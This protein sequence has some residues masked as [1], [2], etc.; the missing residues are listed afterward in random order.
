M[1][2][3][4]RQRI[5]P[6]IFQDQLVYFFF[7]SAVRIIEQPVPSREQRIRRQSRLISLWYRLAGDWRSAPYTHQ[8]WRRSKSCS[9]RA[10]IG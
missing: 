6:T 5:G 9:R 2:P 4:V 8:F 7:G 1:R 10:E 3:L